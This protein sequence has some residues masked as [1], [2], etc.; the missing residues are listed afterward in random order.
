MESSKYF[1]VRAY[2]HSDE[3]LLKCPVVSALDKAGLSPSTWRCYGHQPAQE[4]QVGNLS[5][6][7][8]TEAGEL[9]SLLGRGIHLLAVT[10]EA[11]STDCL[12]ASVGIIWNLE[13]ELAGLVFR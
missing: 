3:T 10:R 12:A 5:W 8:Y 4:W 13:G 9:Q 1:T 2:L 11:C 7:D 6:A